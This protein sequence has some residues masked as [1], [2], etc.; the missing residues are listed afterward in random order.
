[1]SYIEPP[2]GTGQTTVYNRPIPLYTLNNIERLTDL[3]LLRGY[4]PHEVYEV[5]L[6]CNEELAHAA[7]TNSVNT[8][9]LVGYLPPQLGVR[10]AVATVLAVDCDAVLNKCIDMAVAM[11]VRRKV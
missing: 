6:Q 1:M 8:P 2:K 3:A 5:Y 9:L 11:S 7:P 10:R 4:T